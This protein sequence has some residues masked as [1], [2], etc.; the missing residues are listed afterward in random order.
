MSFP[1]KH[2]LMIGATSG[3]GK[4]LSERFV[5]A[6]IKVTAVGR[7]QDRLDEFV[8][9]HGTSKASG[10]AFDLGNTAKIPQFVTD[11]T[12]ASPDIDCLFLN[13]GVQG[14]YDFSKPETV[15]LAAFNSE[16]NVN[17]TSFVALVYAFLP[18]LLSKK[19]DTSIVFTGSHLA[20]I[21]A[22]TMPAYSGSKAALN[23]FTLCLRDQLALS[24]IK[25]IELSPPPVQSELHDYMGDHGRKIGMPLDEFSD[26]AFELLRSGKDQII[27]GTVGPT[28]Q[29]GPAE[30]FL[31]VIEKRRS[32]FEW[33]SKIMLGRP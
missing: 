2:V 26:K 20:I 12:R 10:V 31:E 23:A 6:G 9:K 11:V 25:V 24:N 13:A 8:S 28:G 16:I 33:L 21:P 29:G 3:I 17:F 15:N 27:I 4:G 1:Y 5:Q 30:M 22:V 19:T 14:T 18:F 7:R 32:V